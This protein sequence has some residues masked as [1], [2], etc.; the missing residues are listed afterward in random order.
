MLFINQDPV[1]KVV[2]S[3]IRALHNDRGEL[4]ANKQRRV[5]A[6]FKRGIPGWALPKALEL[7]DLNRVPDNVPPVNWF[8]F[9]DSIEDQAT[10]GW[11]DEERSAIEQR[12]VA[13]GYVVVEPE[14]A[15]LPYPAYEKHRRVIGKRTVEH[16]VKDIVAA[17]T[18]TGVPFDTV[19]AYER[20]HADRDS[21][22]VLQ[23]V[24][25]GLI[26]PEEEL[27]TA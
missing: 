26:V 14:K 23:G 17:L 3:E 4:V 15:P 16:A 6:K 27:V 24:E 19:A 11:T 12:L 25:E 22:A 1:H 20:D 2:R 9:Y 10:Q 8:G 18:T 5:Y 21:T 13:D 7:F